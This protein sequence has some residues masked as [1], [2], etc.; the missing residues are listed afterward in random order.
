MHQA[1]ST[2][3]SPTIVSRIRQRL[4]DCPI[5]GRVRRGLGLCR[6]NSSA[7]PAEMAR[8]GALLYG[9]G[10]ALVAFSLL[11][12]HPGADVEVL[13]IEA[14]LAAL[15]SALLWRWGAR[16]RPCAFPALTALG[17]GMITL[18][19]H[20]GGTGG[21]AFALFY[22][23]AALYAAYF[24]RAAQIT[25]QIALIGGACTV[26]G[27]LRFTGPIGVVMVV[28]TVLVAGLLM[29]TAV[30]RL[31]RQQEELR[32]RAS[33]HPL[34]GL[35]NRSLLRERLEEALRQHRTE[36]AQLAVLVI[37][38]D[39]FKAVNDAL[40][41]ATG[42]QLLASVGAR[43][44]E[45]ARPDDTV[46]HI[47]GDE[48]A[49]LLERTCV[50]EVG[51]A[52]TDVLAAFRSSFVAGGTEI[53][54]NAS[55]GAALGTPGCTGDELLRD[56]DVAMYSAKEGGKGGF[57]IYEPTRHRPTLRRL[58]LA[59]ELRRALEHGEFRL[60]YQPV[61]ALGSGRME[62][63]EALIRWAHPSLG[64]LAPMHFISLAEETGL[65][66]PIG[67]WV[68]AAACDQAARWRAQ[69]SDGQGLAV[70]VNV[71]ARQ[72]REPDF[73]E[74]VLAALGRACLEPRALI[75][76]VTE[77]ALV[78][79]MASVRTKL[80]QLRDVGVRV[81]MDDFGSG[82]SSLAYLHA[83]PVDIVKID[84]VFTAT[85]GAGQQ[86]RLTGAIVR[87]LDN[88]DVV[89]VA[90]GVECSAQ[91]EQL[92]TWGVDHVQGFHVQRPVD[93]AAIT[94]LRGAPLLA[95]AATERAA[96]RRDVN[97]VDSRT[98][99]TAAVRLPLISHVAGGPVSLSPVQPAHSWAEQRGLLE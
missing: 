73:V 45:S 40:G 87:L 96:R 43:L 10:A 67:R 46:A 24:F 86:R 66:V 91:V 2:V 79:D 33:H 1:A 63:V 44:A 5:L 12:P 61:V 75:L 17:S 93:A 56:A 90:E 14:A 48:F 35:A 27:A 52:S 16:L 50:A 22:V 99:A 81:A 88:L 55:L 36:P 26:S 62:S 72:L 77:S 19:I 65:I 47:G 3:A 97:R 7:T 18:A 53:F 37:D 51:R 78:E 74:S 58:G 64:R 80:Q 39:N 20:V 68:L 38:L 82:Y 6:P 29:R 21:A 60:E 69:D 11:L 31:R 95:P 98:R 89:T 28:G 70:A 32:H 49:V 9:P 4:S 76:E 15:I 13:G 42:D 85:M 92:R 25:L 94:A 34:T 54:V 30:E 83:L 57:E 59:T 41:H 23:W 8:G 71:S 84:R